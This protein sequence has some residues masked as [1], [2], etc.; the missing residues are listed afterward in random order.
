M[1]AAPN[2]A[3]MDITRPQ[4]IYGGMDNSPWWN[5]VHK[6]ERLLGID[7]DSPDD[8]PGRNSK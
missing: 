4:E 6:V 8:Y 2:N 7:I 1:R 5:L 3:G